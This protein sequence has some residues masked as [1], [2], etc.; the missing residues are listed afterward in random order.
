MKK[1][2]YLLLACLLITA[3]N[4]RAQKEMMSK[5]VQIGQQDKQFELRKVGHY[6]L[7]NG[8][9]IMGDDLP[10]TKIYVRTDPRGIP[11]N[12]WPSGYI[13][14]MIGDDVI[15]WDMYQS[16][17][18][19]LTTLNNNTNV[20]FK[21]YAGESDYIKIDMYLDDPN[22][23]GFSAVGRQGGEQV[24][25]LNKNMPESVVVHEMLHA[26]GM[27]HEQSRSDR[28]N[29]VKVNLDNV[30]E[31]YKHNFQIE[32]GIAIGDYDY[33][34]IMHYPADAFA[35]SGGNASIQCKN[36]QAVSNCKLG[37]NVLSAKDIAAL[38]R[39]F[40]SNQA[41]AR[42]D[43]ANAFNIKVPDA[44][45]GDLANGV[46]RIKIKNTGKYLDI[47]D[48]SRENGAVLQ[49]WDKF[50]E[51]N[52]LFAVIKSVYGSYEFKAMHSNRYLSVDRASDKD[53]AGI[54]Q[55]DYANQNNQRFYVMWVESHKGYVIQGVQSNKFL[56]LLGLNNGGLIIQQ[57][58]AIQTFAF[59]WV[60]DIPIVSSAEKIKSHL[61]GGV[62]RQTQKKN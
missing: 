48:V 49:Q 7:L 20:R 26:L 56:G 25:F 31:E 4:L 6:F 21:P 60:K 29:F 51:A 33:Q 41:V 27:W 44:K 55:W 19:A 62:L 3:G 22:L 30:K 17:M 1:F 58:K 16:V 35:V 32:P 61:P 8:D 53:L 52:Q 45:S 11:V 9:I 36:G 12:L 15:K 14:V 18:Q 39:L 59:E 50:T 24:L 47:K 38:N 23:G 10:R 34:S 37:G 57:T 43:L 54:I 46:Y 5:K 13:P 28:D 40:S 2:A 42:I